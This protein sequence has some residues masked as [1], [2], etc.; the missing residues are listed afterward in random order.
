MNI[1]QR[2]GISLR[3]TALAS[4]FA[5]KG[6]RIIASFRSWNRQGTRTIEKHAIIR[7]VRKNYQFVSSLRRTKWKYIHS[8]I[9]GYRTRLYNK[10]SAW[11]A[12]FLQ[13]WNEQGIKKTITTPDSQNAIRI[14]TIHKS[15]GLEFKAVIIPFCDWEIDHNPHHEN[16]LWCN[17]KEPLDDFR[18]SRY[19]MDRSWKKA[20]MPMHT[21]T[22]RCTPTSTISTLH[23]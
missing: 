21:S 2:T 12:S 8:G 18:L 16:I 6:E 20:F 5:E 3:K 19:V 15:K 7:N 4:Y 1:R 10:H 22:K 14:M 17:Q 13:W 23:M 9:P 11:P